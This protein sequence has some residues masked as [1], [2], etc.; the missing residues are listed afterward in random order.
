MPHFIENQENRETIYTDRGRCS[1]RNQI[2][3]NSGGVAGG[4][5]GF[6]KR[7][8]RT[9][10]LQLC[11]N[12]LLLAATPISLSCKLRLCELMSFASALRFE[13]MLQYT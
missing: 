12:C 8:I 11:R 13:F 3:G 10:S 5:E 6:R 9:T 2:I 1:K 4:H 7:R